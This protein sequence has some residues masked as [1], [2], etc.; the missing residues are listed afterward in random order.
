[1]AELVH[2]YDFGIRCNE[3]KKVLVMVNSRS[4]TSSFAT[5]LWPSFDTKVCADGGANRLYDGLDPD[6]ISKYR[7]DFIVGDLDSIR[8]D[9]CDA[10]R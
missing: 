6:L 8:Q 9:V 1:M 5:S 7:P 10:F 3:K 2:C 4:M